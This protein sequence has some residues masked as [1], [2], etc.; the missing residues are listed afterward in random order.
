M[1]TIVD[2]DGLVASFSDVIDKPGE[3]EADVVFL[4]GGKHFG[5]IRKVLALRCAVLQRMLF[6]NFKEAHARD[7]IPLPAFEDI[8][9]AFREFLMF[10]HTGSASLLDESEVMA[11]FEIAEFFEVRELVEKCTKALQAVTLSHSNCVVLLAFAIQHGMPLVIRA[12]CQHIEANADAALA[13]SKQVAFLPETFLTYLFASNDICISEATLVRILI[14]ASEEKQA[15][16][17]KLIRLPRVSASDMMN[18][19]VPSGLFDQGACLAAMAYC[20]DPKSVE[21]PAEVVASRGAFTF[22]GDRTTSLFTDGYMHSINMKNWG[23]K[24]PGVSCGK[25]FSGDSG[26]SGWVG[27]DTWVRAA[28]PRRRGRGARQSRAWG[29]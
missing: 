11:L 16:L 3:N 12:A 20:R 26:G 18:V 24:Q 10:L 15:A 29:S 4:V 5:G 21:L 23:N 9:S 6:G 22:D 2:T 17:Q 13:D 1:E 27:S 19:V 28:W 25:W 14:M 7:P 8:P